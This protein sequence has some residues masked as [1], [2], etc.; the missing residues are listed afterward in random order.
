MGLSFCITFSRQLFVKYKCFEMWHVESLFFITM[1]IK[2]YLS[3][4]FSVLVNICGRGVGGLKLIPCTL[5]DRFAN[6]R[7]FL[8]L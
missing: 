5:S 4:V 1:L 8:S 2:L 6:L 7:K 3:V